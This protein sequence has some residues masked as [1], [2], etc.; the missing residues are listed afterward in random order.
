MEQDFTYS[1]E[2]IGHIFDPVTNALTVQF[3][4]KD[5][6]TYLRLLEMYDKDEKESTMAEKKKAPAKKET[7]KKATPKKKEKPVKKAPAKK[8]K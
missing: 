4:C 5:Y 2:L 1:M 8:G 7:E 3:R 6:A